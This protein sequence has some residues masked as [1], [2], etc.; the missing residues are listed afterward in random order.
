MTPGVIN[1]ITIT[2][3]ISSNI[4]IFKQFEK[5]STGN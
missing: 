2:I 3:I 1:I 4:I 5:D